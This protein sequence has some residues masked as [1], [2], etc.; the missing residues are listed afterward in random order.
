MN[1]PSRKL[2]PR[3]S[4]RGEAVCPEGSLNLYDIGTIFTARRES[5]A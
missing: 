2:P 4:P 3:L 5:A 1:G